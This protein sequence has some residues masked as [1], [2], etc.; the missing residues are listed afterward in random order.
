LLLITNITPLQGLKFE[1]Y[2]DFYKY[3]AALPLKYAAEQQYICS[4]ELLPRAI[5]A[6]EQRTIK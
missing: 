1:N 5:K 2:F 6:V 3:Y 4:G